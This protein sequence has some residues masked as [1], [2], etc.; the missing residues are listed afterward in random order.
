MPYIKGQDRFKFSNTLRRLKQLKLIETVGELNYLITS[1]CKIYLEQKGEKYTH[2][3]D[4]LG[5]LTAVREEWYRRRTAPYEDKKI[6]EKGE[7]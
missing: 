3:N 4:I 6:K 2:H 7:V 1:I 5:V